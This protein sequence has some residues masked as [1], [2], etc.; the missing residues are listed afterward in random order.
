MD[1]GSERRSFGRYIRERRESA[2]LTQGEL[3]AAVGAS[4]PTVSAWERGEL[5]ERGYCSP[6]V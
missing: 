2:G 4:Q 6:F 1:L 5:A 3:G